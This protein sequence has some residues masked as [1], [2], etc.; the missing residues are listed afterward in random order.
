MRG[1]GQPNDYTNRL[2]VLSD[3]MTLNENV[4]TSRS[5]TSTAAPISAMSIG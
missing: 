4:L 2:L 3:G 5:S 1:L